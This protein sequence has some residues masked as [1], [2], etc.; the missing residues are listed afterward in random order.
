LTRRWAQRLA[1]ASNPVVSAKAARISTYFETR[2][3]VA[4]C[5]WWKRQ[6]AERRE[7]TNGRD[8]GQI[9]RKD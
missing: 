4:I 3:S 2:E 8:F 7:E 9:T 1:D 5:G 6:H